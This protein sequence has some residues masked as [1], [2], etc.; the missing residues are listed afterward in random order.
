MS[1][2][3]ITE[4]RE[5]NDILAKLLEP[6]GPLS[7]DPNHLSADPNHNARMKEESDLA[8]TLRL[9]LGAE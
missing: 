6:A 1:Y 2:G 3:Y 7:A 9:L 5:L 8:L 4:N